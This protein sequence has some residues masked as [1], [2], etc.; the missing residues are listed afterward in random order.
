MV[1]RKTR[2][3][4]SN[5]DSNKNCRV[6]VPNFGAPS[7]NQWISTNLLKAEGP[8][9]IVTNTATVF[10][11]FR[12]Y[13]R[14]TSARRWSDRVS[15]DTSHVFDWSIDWLIV[16]KQRLLPL[17]VGKPIRLSYENAASEAV[18]RCRLIHQCHGIR[19]WAITSKIKHAIKHKNKS[20]KT[21]TTVA[22]LI[23]ILPFRT[24]R[25]AI[26]G[27]K[28]KQNANEGCNS[29]ATVVQVL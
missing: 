8:S 9:K 2:H 18:R 25:H 1:S 16:R 15:W 14:S 13:S 19:K 26:I 5:N 3:F 11:Y 12:H 27:C 29:C 7:I 10:N 28:L 17:H 24:G 6:T 22:A 20:Y 23:S 4:I 21:C